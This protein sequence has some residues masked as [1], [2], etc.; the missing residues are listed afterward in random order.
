MQIVAGHVSRLL[1]VT[2][3]STEARE[4]LHNVPPRRSSCCSVLVLLPVASLCHSVVLSVR[5]CSWSFAA[6]ECP[7]PGAAA[8]LPTPDS[9]AA[10]P[11]IAFSVYSLGIVNL[12]NEPKYV[13]ES[14]LG[15]SR[16]S[17][18][19]RAP[20]L[21]P[22]VLSDRL[23]WAETV[24]IYGRKTSTCPYSPYKYRLPNRCRAP[25][26]LHCEGLPR[27]DR[28]RNPPK[29]GTS[30][31]CHTWALACSLCFHLSV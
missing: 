24:A 25:A 18:C 16:L 17:H 21:C 5:C 8:C 4:L 27:M 28:G 12:L 22:C 2:A 29:S 19:D 13:S 31:M 10:F 11:A 3:Q 1:A 15:N 7:Q 14:L 26:L 30:S 23:C 9:E 6:S 20:A